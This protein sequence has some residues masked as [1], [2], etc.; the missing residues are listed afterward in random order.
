MSRIIIWRIWYGNRG[1]LKIPKTLQNLRLKAH[2]MLR[3]E[4]VDRWYPL[5]SDSCSTFNVGLTA[6]SLL[7]AFGA[8]QRLHLCIG[9][10]IIGVPLSGP[11][12]KFWDW[13]FSLVGPR[14]L[15]NE[16]EDQF[17]YRLRTGRANKWHAALICD[18]V[19]PLYTRDKFEQLDQTSNSASIY[20]ASL[21]GFMNPWPRGFKWCRILGYPYALVLR[22]STLRQLADWLN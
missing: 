20:R 8:E 22:E 9:L 19:H 14:F 3:H 16:S 10:P 11:H 13:T 2:K 12:W 6:T 15:F 7:D 1:K 18:R 21:A 5:F 4:N 17:Y